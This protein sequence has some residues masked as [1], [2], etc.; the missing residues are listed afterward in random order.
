MRRQT[1][2]RPEPEPQGGEYRPMLEI[3]MRNNPTTHCYDVY[4]KRIY[5][6]YKWKLQGLRIIYRTGDTPLG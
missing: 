4:G 2:Q 6:R 1:K 5:P 3:L